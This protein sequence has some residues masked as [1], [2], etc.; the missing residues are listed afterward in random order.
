MSPLAVLIAS[1][2]TCRDELQS[3][4]QDAVRFTDI[5]YRHLAD[6]DIFAQTIHQLTSRDVQVTFIL[7]ATRRSSVMTSGNAGVP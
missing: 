7:Q 2:D 1:L 5:V 4:P 6:S 3:A